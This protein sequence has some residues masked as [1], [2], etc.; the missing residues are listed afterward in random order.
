M[1]SSAWSYAGATSTT[2]APTKCSPVSP[3][4][5]ADALEDG[6]DRPADAEV[7]DIAGPDRAEAEP[8]VV[9]EVGFPVQ[10]A[11]NSD[12]NRVI[13]DEEPVFERAPEHRAVRDRRVEVGIPGIQVGV[14]VHERDRAMPS[15]DGLEHR[16]RDR[17]V[18]ADRH[19]PA[20]AADQVG[21]VA[22]DLPH[23]RRDVERRDRDVAGVGDLHGL[24][25]CEAELDVV[26][27]AQVSRGLA[28]RRRPEA[29]SRAVGRPGVEWHAQH[30][31]VVVGDLVDRGEP[32]EG[33]GAGEAGHH[34]AVDR[35][36][37][38]GA[39]VR[40]CSSRLCRTVGASQALVRV[41]PPLGCSTCP[42]KALPPWPARKQTALAM[43][44]TV[45]SWP[46]GTRSR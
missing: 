39:G 29:C 8:P 40:H 12:V 37:R 30:G 1:V 32:G 9:G 11:A 31:D 35:S 46:V 25:R 41:T 19:Y 14:E 20:V 13:L 16:Q 28:H 3:G 22:A 34:A 45:A 6:V 36:H 10:R 27:G 4:Q 33:R 42:T 21:G 24:E 44:S 26:A 43:S 15:R 23:G 18:A 5:V 7:V 2:S 38:F 17:V